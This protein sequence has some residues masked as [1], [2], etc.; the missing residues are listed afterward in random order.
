MPQTA[1]MYVELALYL[2]PEMPQWLFLKGRTLEALGR[3]KEASTI[4]QTIPK[5]NDFYVPASIHFAVLAYKQEHL[6]QA[7]K[8][9]SDLEEKYPDQIDVGL[10]RADIYIQEHRFNEAVNVYT[11][12][13]GKEKEVE[14]HAWPLY[15]L[16]SIAYDKVGEWPKAEEDLNRALELNEQQV[17]VLNYLGYSWLERGINLSRV[18]PLIQAAYRQRPLDPAIMDSMAWLLYHMRLY[19]EAQVL[20]ERALSMQSDDPVIHEH[21]GDVYW[22][23]GQCIEARFEWEHAESLITE[24]KDVERLH[25]KQQ[26]GVIHE[27]PKIDPKV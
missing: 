17:D 21:L 24:Q 15:F 2:Q 12:L 9:L 22:Q 23:L 14:H 8:I 10:A 3:V 7:L 18:T 11:D 6:S 4:Y 20:L 27:V 5:E 1:L 13:L 16:R 25:Q 19:R 26:S